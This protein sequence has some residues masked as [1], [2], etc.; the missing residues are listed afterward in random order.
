MEAQP[1]ITQNISSLKLPM[2]KTGDCDLWSMRMEQY[3]THIDY[4]L[5][6][7][8]INGDSPVPKPPAVGTVEDA[9]M[10]LLRSLPPAWN[11]IALIMRN[12][13]DIETLSMHDLYNNLKVYE[14]EIKGQSSS[15]SNSHNVAFVSFE[16]TSSINETVNVAHYIP[17]TGS[18]EQPSASSY[19]DDVAMITIRIKKFMKKTRRNLNFNGKE[20]VGFD[21]IR[22]EC[23][24][25]HRIGHFA[26]ECRTPRNQG[27][28]SG[29]NE[30]R[31]IPVKTPVSTLVVQDGLGGYDW[32]Y[33]AE[34]GP[35][36]FVLMAYSSDSSN[37][38]NFEKKIQKIDRL[39]RSLLIQ[40]LSND[41]YSLIDSNKTAK[42]LWDALTRHMLGSEYGEQDMKAAVLY[43]H[44]TFKATKGIQN[45]G[46]VND[47]M[48]SKKK[49]IVFTSDPLALVAE[50]TK[51]SKRKEKVIVSS[52]SEG[53]DDELKKITTLLA[54]AFN[55]K[56][57]YSKL[58][59]NN[60]R[61]SSATSLENKKQ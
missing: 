2:L 11:N 36:D 22:V 33:Q 48:K 10:K 43:E 35:T 29:D 7:V 31:V 19:A 20:P 32:S 6:E 50:Q 28:R 9:N 3:L 15:S 37:L 27:N 21:K 34:K 47:T 61:N 53:S 38:S 46:D 58:T 59:N 23:Y 17:A 4:A 14:A 52:E 26:R 45:Q 42:D 25:C 54:K 41:I 18:K 5:W 49:V 1:Q 39:T 60:L 12:K 55:R 8:I 51:V 44:K 40:G 57:F 56:K 30:R 16:N 13:P 24:N